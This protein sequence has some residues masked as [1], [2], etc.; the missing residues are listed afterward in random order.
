[1]TELAAQ[2]GDG[3]ALR[4][5]Y[6]SL[7]ELIAQSIGLVGAAGGAGLLIPAVFATA[8]NGTWLAYLLATIGLLFAS[9][10]ITQFAKRT[11]SPGALYTYAARGLGPIWGVIAGWSLL[12]AYG[13]GA[14]GILQGTVN[15]VVVLFKDVGVG[16]AGTGLLASVAITV[17]VTIGAWF[18]TWRDIRLSTRTTLWIELS[19]VVLILFVIGAALFLH[20]RW[21]DP[22]QLALAAVKP[23]QL[24]LGMVLA[25]FSFT[26][27]ESVT[28]L[29]VEAREPFR[30]I[31]RAVIVS[32]LGP[33]ALF[34]AA[35]YG[36]VA[37]FQ[38]AAT[39]LDQANAPLSAV[40]HGI[41]LGALGVLIDAGVALSFFAAFF[42]SINAA[43]RLLYTFARQGL[44]HSATGRAHA[45]NATPHIAVTLIA[46]LSLVV[47]VVF[48]LRGTSLFDAY[49]YLS[50]I[51]TFGF[52]LT[53]VIVAIAAPVFLRRRGELKP[54]D[55]AISVIAVV[56]I[57]IPFVGSIY[58]AA[59]GAYAVLPYVF[60]ALLA[61]GFAWFVAL[62]IF[63]PHRL[64]DIE[65]ELADDGADQRIGI[66]PVV[67]SAS[68][69]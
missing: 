30:L 15:E 56:L 11:A 23:D 18:I 63:A 61:A 66:K 5:G 55:V 53:Y 32:I 22:Q 51:A 36:L 50:T 2:A 39:P 46:L 42:S 14:A 41:H 38:G 26:G 57:G 9:W 37:L 4:R 49:G 67:Q 35:S 20:H 13:I 21:V 6:L 28:A 1:M 48:Q 25:F 10:S 7:S 64:H 60:A 24:R 8:G 19:T 27:F 68:T 44:L 69:A 47:G 43:A 62:R 65:A 54:L 17:A 31:P 59:P 33:A 40:A 45:G 12:I 29:G 58:P 3:G 16:A 34:L 52:L